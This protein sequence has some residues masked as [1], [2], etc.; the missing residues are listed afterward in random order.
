MLVLL[1]VLD[2]FMVNCLEM[3]IPVDLL[4]SLDSF[5]C[6]ISHFLGVNSNGSCFFSSLQLEWPIQFLEIF[7]CLLF[8]FFFNLYWLFGWLFGSVYFAEVE[9]TKVWVWEHRQ[10]V[11][12]KIFIQTKGPKLLFW[13]LLFR[14]LLRMW[15]TAKR[16]DAAWSHLWHLTTLRSIIKLYQLWK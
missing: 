7:Y 16:G 1:I 2:F 11:M 14:V 13:S 5:C 6:F 4:R 8:F 12:R 9:L 15:L 3:N 10:F